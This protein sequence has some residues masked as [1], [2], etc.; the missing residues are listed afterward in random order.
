MKKLLPLFILGTS[1]LALAHTEVT[2]V[3]LTPAA[4]QTAPRTLLL[5]FSEPIELR[6]STFRVVPLPGGKLPADAAKTALT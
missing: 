5:K 1:G 3:T 2:S 4:S 6:F